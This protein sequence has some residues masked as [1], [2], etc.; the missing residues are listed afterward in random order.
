MSDKFETNESGLNPV[1]ADTGSKDIYFSNEDYAKIIRENKNPGAPA[2]AK[3]K[4][5]RRRGNTVLSTYMFFIIVIAL[6]MLL[7][8]YAIFC[9]NDV[10]GMTKSQTSITVSYTQRITDPS[11][12]IDILADNGLVTCKNFCKILVKLETMLL[13]R[14]TSLDGPFE[15]GTY[16]LNGKMGVENMLIAMLGEAETAETVTLTFPEGYTVADIVKKLVD[17]EVCK[18]KAALLSVIQSTEFT[19]YSLVASRNPKETIPY[20]LEGYLFPDTYNFYIGQGPSSTVETF[21]KNTEAKIT[22]EFR[23]RAKELG[24][25]MDEVIIIAS[26]VQAEA[27]NAKQMPTIAGIIEN[28][29]RDKVNFPTLGCNSTADYIKNKVKPSL[30]SSSSHTA[31]YYL[32]YYNTNNDSLVSGLPEGPICNP[33]LDAIKAVLW[34]ENTDDYFFFHDNKKNL[35]TAKNNTEFKE[36]IRRF[37]PYLL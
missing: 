20:R 11:E 31:E 10:F 13:S 2:A 37:A 35:Y 23:E 29:L 33:G 24:Y 36:K 26:I 14:Q 5:R 3:T 12:A 9:L 25:T 19:S 16:Y 7:S 28:R 21:L 27:A 17:N 32:K 30:T 1:D 18:D 15:P 34:P 6:S 4:K 22:D 8:V